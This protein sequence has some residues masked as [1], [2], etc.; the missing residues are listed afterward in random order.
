M[1]YWSEKYSQIPTFIPGKAVSSLSLRPPPD[2]S[3]RPD[4]GVPSTSRRSASLCPP[5]GFGLQ[6]QRVEGILGKIVGGTGK[7]SIRDRLRHI[8]YGG[9]RK[10]ARVRRA[11][12]PY[13][14]SYTGNNTL[15]ATPFTAPRAK[16]GTNPFPLV[17]PRQLF[18]VHPNSSINFSGFCQFKV[19]R[20]PSRHVTLHENYFLSFQRALDTNTVLN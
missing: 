13:G 17:F 14:L 4:P 11:T 3:T 9:S 18:R 16:P 20:R 2:C 10:L 7:T 12:A 15:F 19:G 6:S 8:L 5:F 1:Q